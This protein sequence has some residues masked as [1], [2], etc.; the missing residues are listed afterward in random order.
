MSVKNRQ[1]E[2]S[3]EDRGS[4]GRKIKEY[5][6]ENTGVVEGWGCHSIHTVPA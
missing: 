4:G 1:K 5:Q 3:K 6:E 2:G